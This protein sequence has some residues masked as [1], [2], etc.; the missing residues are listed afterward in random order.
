M[1]RK[2]YDSNLLDY[3]LAV[4]LFLIVMIPTLLLIALEWL[5]CK[6]DTW[7]RG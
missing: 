6:I 4:I 5:G 2:N 1:L 7:L 3:I